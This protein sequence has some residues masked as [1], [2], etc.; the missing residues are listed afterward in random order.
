MDTCTCV[1]LKI[2]TKCFQ[3]VLKS[4]CERKRMRVCCQRS[5]SLSLGGVSYID[6]CIF[7]AISGA[8]VYS[9]SWLV[10]RFLNVEFAFES[11]W[12]LAVF[13]Y[14]GFEFEAVGDKCLHETDKEEEECKKPRKHAPTN[15]Q[16]FKQGH[17]GVSKRSTHGALHLE[18][19]F[20]GL[21]SRTTYADVNKIKASECHS[22][23]VL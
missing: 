17:V 23:P 2:R 12:K 8:E 22:V 21:W 5:R 1:F 13:R 3:K 16:P 4:R 6:I 19:V 18:K 7:Q 9:Q 14:G 20:C 15:Q 10:K 11:L